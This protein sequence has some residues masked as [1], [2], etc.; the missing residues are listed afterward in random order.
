MPFTPR[1]CTAA[2][3][4]VLVV[5]D[6]PLIR[7]L[8]AEALGEREGVRVLAAASAAEA[9]GLVRPEAVDVLFTDIDLG[10]GPDGFDLARVACA[11]RPGL[12]VAYTSGRL[13]EVDA[14]RAL[15]GSLF[16]PKP[17]RPT[18]V[19]DRLRDLVSARRP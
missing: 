13:R 17:Y 14:G 18:Q 8:A 19:Y 7:E 12:R 3:G 16:V 2:L 11:L 6:E 4:T 5:E 1:P 15:P 10:P 9:L